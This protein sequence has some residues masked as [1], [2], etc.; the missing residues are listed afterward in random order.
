VPS[1]EYTVKDG[2]TVSVLAI[3]DEFIEQAIPTPDTATPTPDTIGSNDGGTVEP[4]PSG[5]GEGGSSGSSGGSAGVETT[6]P[7]DEVLKL[8]GLSEDEA[9]RIAESKGWVVRVSSR[10]GKD[11]Q[12]TADYVMNRVNLAIV[13]GKVT[14]VSVG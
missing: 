10:D 4:M 11:F 7:K 6:L 3:T 2:Y 9:T 1:Y 14:G 13:E 5:G 8:V 12:L